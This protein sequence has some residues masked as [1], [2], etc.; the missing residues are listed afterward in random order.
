[1]STIK[2]KRMTSAPGARRRRIKVTPLRLFM[3]LLVIG[4]GLVAGLFT[5]ARSWT[6]SAKYFPVQ[7]IT[8]SAQSGTINWRMARAA[9]A[10]FVYLRATDGARGR[11]SAFNDYL[12][13]AVANDMRHGAIHRYD[14]CSSASA[15]ATR[16]IATVPRDPQMLPPVVEMGFDLPCTARPN[17]DTLLAELNTFLNQIETHAAKPAVIR[18]S[19]EFEAAYDVAG[20]INRTLWVD[21]DFFVP[22]YTTRPWTMWTASTWKRINGIEGP[23][24]WNAV[25]Q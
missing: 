5:L 6:P 12:A 15:Q 25:R 23:I 13:G 9:G 20:G 14:L 1:M 3:L 24:E 10:D 16:F 19:R 21:G 2:A 18:T 17:R 7:G 11:D 4:G 8:L 22:D